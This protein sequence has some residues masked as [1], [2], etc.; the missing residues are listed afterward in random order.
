MR[1][2]RVPP[3]PPPP[4]PSLPEELPNAEDGQDSE[5]ENKEREGEEGRAAETEAGG[6]EGT[7]AETPSEVEEVDRVDV[8]EEEE[9]EKKGVEEEEKKG[10]EDEEEEEGMWGE[11]FKSHYDSKPYGEL[12]K[13]TCLRITTAANVGAYYKFKFQLLICRAIQA[14]TTL[15]LVHTHYTQDTV[16]TSDSFEYVRLWYWY[17]VLGLNEQNIVGLFLNEPIHT[18]TGPSSIGMDISFPGV[19]HVYGIPEH[20]DSLS[21][22]TTKWANQLDQCLKL[23]APYLYNW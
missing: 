13:I 22:K 17:T 4:P 10:E 3:P 23:R 8:Q 21:L 12:W 11:T 18:T 14:Y 20:A 15:P 5:D 9:E 2:F 19:E 1:S 7:T 6:V 16:Y